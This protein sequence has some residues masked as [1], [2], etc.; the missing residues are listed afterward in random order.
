MRRFLSHEASCSRARAWGSLEL[1]GEL[2]QL[3]RVLLA[4]HLRR[5]A[6][7]AELVERMRATTALVR[8][9]PLE[10]LGRAL[11]LPARQPRRG[12]VIAL[13]LAAAATLAALAAGLGM[14]AGSAGRTPAQP[15]TA[16]EDIAFLAGAP[17]PSQEIRQTRGLGREQPTKERVFP[18]GRRGGNV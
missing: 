12:R 9:A 18:P 14:L 2:S 13:R 5:C 3:E 4:A 6:D 1:D 10:R 7:C 17:T 11:I 16:P 15:T 8:T